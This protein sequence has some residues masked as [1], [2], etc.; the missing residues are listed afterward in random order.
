MK[1]QPH[2]PQPA[3]TTLLCADGFGPN[4]EGPARAPVALLP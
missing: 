3:F 2:F 1:I 4:D